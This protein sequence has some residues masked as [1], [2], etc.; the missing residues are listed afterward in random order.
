MFS[1]IAQ[2]SRTNANSSLLLSLSAQERL[3][4]NIS[5]IFAELALDLANTLSSQGEALLS[6]ARG[7]YAPYRIKNHTGS[8]IY[9]WSDSDGSSD[10]NELNSTMI[11]DGKSIDWW[12]DDWKT[13]REVHL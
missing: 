1:D 9:V 10:V 8:S 2:V 4:V 13:M 3:D 7:S 11:E 6:K 12:F 5:T